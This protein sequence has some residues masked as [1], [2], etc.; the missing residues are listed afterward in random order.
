M[1]RA[2]FV[3]F[4]LASAKCFAFGELGL[5]FSSP[6][7]NRNVPVL[8]LGYEGPNWKFTGSTAGVKS[9]LYY[10][11][12]YGLAAYK[13]WK[14][15]ELWGYEVQ[16]GFGG[17]IYYTARG[18][19][20]GVNAPLEQTSD[21]GVGPAILVQWNFPYWFL[22]LEATMALQN[23]FTTIFT[24]SVPDNAVFAVGFRW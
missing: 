10:Q 11:S 16:T 17:G 1:L 13:Y 14:S 6:Y 19:R 15:G 9:Q 12:T 24:S 4:I 21:T 18:F 23:I 3:L 5:G 2:V 8:S 7:I 20:D 22:K